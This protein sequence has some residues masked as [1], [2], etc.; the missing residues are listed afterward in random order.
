MGGGSS[1][2]QNDSDDTPTEGTERPVSKAIS[3][4]VLDG[5][6]ASGAALQ[7][8]LLVETLRPD[9]TDDDE[10]IRS[11]DRAL[12]HHRRALELTRKM[13]NE[14]EMIVEQDK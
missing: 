9:R 1:P 13:Y 2:T 10:V 6:L 4:H 7:R 14:N 5:H 12:E 11:I 8:Y 3:Q